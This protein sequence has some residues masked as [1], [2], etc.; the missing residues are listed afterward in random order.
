MKRQCRVR[1]APPA[2]DAVHDSGTQDSD[3]VEIG[4]GTYVV[5]RAI[6]IR[7]P[8]TLRGKGMGLTTVH[9]H[10]ACC[11]HDWGIMVNADSVTLEGFT[12]TPRTPHARRGS[13]G[14]TQGPGST[15]P[16]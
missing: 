3:V 7:R 12:G 14:K 10:K 4:A 9:V 13:R 6:Y 5:E 2:Q 11:F 1:A 15:S 16:S 8:I